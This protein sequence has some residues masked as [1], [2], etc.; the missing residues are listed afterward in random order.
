MIETTISEPVIVNIDILKEMPEYLLEFT[1]EL[2]K[3]HMDLKIINSCTNAS[4]Y[5]DS[6]ML[7]RIMN[8]LISNAVKYGSDYLNVYI[9]SGDNVVIILENEISDNSVNITNIFEKFYT[10]DAGG[11]GGTGLGLYIAREFVH[12]IDGRI[13]AKK[14]QMFSG[15]E[16]GGLYRRS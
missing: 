3:K 6:F 15:K 4:I 14:M 1:D 16:N 9:S 11:N 13:T 7:K 2:K 12:K 8:N 10:S 5:A